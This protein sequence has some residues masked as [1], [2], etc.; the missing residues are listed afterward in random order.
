LIA[1]KLQ[2]E[3][4]REKHDA[5]RKLDAEKKEGYKVFGDITNVTSGSLAANN[6]FCI[7]KQEILNHTVTKVAA[8]KQKEK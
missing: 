5:K 6:M 2:D 7:S 3:A 4:S 1:A 8:L